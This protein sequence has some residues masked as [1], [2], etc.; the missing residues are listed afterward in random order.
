MLSRAIYTRPTR[1]QLV[2][3]NE[4]CFFMTVVDKLLD[5]ICIVADRKKSD[6]QLRSKEKSLDAYVCTPDTLQFRISF[7][8]I[9]ALRKRK[10]C[11]YLQIQELLQKVCCLISSKSCNNLFIKINFI[12]GIISR[13]APTTMVN[14]GNSKLLLHS[15]TSKSQSLTTRPF[16]IYLVLPCCSLSLSPRE[17]RVKL[18]TVLFNPAILRVVPCRLISLGSFARRP[19]YS[20]QAVSCF[21]V[22]QRAAV[23]R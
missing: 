23:S 1:K 2:L 4:S 8:L 14:N 21:A 6:T 20:V 17:Q 5:A 19:N 22:A 16:G 3:Q 10:Q 11:K 13:S 15:Q 9:C 18:A 7:A 12:C